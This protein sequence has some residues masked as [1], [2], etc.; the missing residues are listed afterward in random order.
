MELAKGGDAFDWFFLAMAHWRLGHK[1]EAR[2]WYDK[3]AAWDA[4][5]LPPP[6]NEELR[7]FRAEAAALLGVNDL[8]EDVFARP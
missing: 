8:P 1:D 2:A 5:N 7:R 3:A 6:E 4:K